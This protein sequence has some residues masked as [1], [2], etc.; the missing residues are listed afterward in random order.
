VKPF[1]ERNPIVVGAFSVAVLSVLMLFAFSLNRFTFLRGVYVIEADFAD[2]AGLVPENEVR[3]AGLKV[4]K[5]RSV[6]LSGRGGTADATRDRVRVSMEISNGVDLGSASEAEIKLKTL[7]GAKFVDV[8][9]KGGAPYFEAGDVLPLEQTRIPFE[10][11]EVTNRTVQTIGDLD[12]DALNDMLRQLAVQFDDPD[13]NFGRA[14]KGLSTATKSLSERDED[15]KSLVQSAD[16]VVG[17]LAGRSD[18]LA[19]IIDNGAKIL[20]ALEARRDGVQRFV[21]GSDALAEELA[22]L[23]SSTRKDLDPALEHLHTVLQVVSGNVKNVEESIRVLGPSAES[24][25]RTATQ[26]NWVDIFTESL[27]GVP[28]PPGLTLQDLLGSFG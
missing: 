8:L 23:L 22:G 21:R 3:V 20:Q 14:L 5:V 2:A 13:G 9:P 12:A 10:L 28:V 1:R 24:F 19:A 7:L 17:V 11:Y 6:E 4:G 25:G 26:G 16:K 27:L 18:E 15:L